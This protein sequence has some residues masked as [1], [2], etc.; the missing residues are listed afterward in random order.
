MYNG[1]TLD[2]IS[3][4]ESESKSQGSLTFESSCQLSAEE[5]VG[6]FTLPVAFQWTVVPPAE[7]QVVQVD[8]T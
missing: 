8:A 4:S 5:H 7:E 3:E 2:S 1:N 6:Q